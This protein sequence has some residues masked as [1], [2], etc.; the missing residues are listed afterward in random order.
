M[1]QN[2]KLTE[3][4]GNR[5]YDWTTLKKNRSNSKLA[6]TRDATSQRGYTRIE[7]TIPFLTNIDVLSGL[8]NSFVDMIP[9]HIIYSTPHS[10]MWNAFC[11]NMKH[12]LIVCDEEI[13]EDPKDKKSPTGLAIVVYSYNKLTKD[14]SGFIVR[15]WQKRMLPILERYTLAAHLP[16][17]LITVAATSRRI[18]NSKFRSVELELNGS[19]Y[20]KN[21]LKE[22]KDFTY[23]SQHSGKFIVRTPA[24]TQADMDGFGFVD[25][26]NCHLHIPHNA[27]AKGSKRWA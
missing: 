25:H 20:E 1:L 21:M 11:D 16:I 9:P 8:V 12:T 26:H 7:I 22:Q 19:I 24:V 3:D 18:T 23:M 2:R 5:W 27:I 15:D 13:K 6:Q 4:L 10:S 14:L 17:D